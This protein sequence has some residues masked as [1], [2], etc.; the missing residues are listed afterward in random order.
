MKYVSLDLETTGIEDKR[1]ENILMLSMV[2]ED[3]L[4]IQPLEK[5]SNFTCFIKQDNIQGETYALSMNSWILDIISGR[6]INL[7]EI[8]VIQPE[9]ITW[10]INQ[11][12]DY[13]F[14][15]GNNKII[16]AG[17]N[18]GNFDYQF[19]PSQIQKRFSHA[20]IDP[21]PIFLDFLKDK[22]VP[23]LKTCKLRSGINTEVSHDAYKDALD[24][25]AVLRTKYATNK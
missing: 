11:F 10:K 16:L 12:L 25:I 20:M 21:G 3:T 1:P 7:T 19:L 24:T 6:S 15:I 5:L 8:P 14:G 4:D 2:V 22:K 17:K 13:Y 18:V 23:D 9:L